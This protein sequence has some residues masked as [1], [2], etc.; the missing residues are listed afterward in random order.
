MKI[1]F[2][3]NAGVSN[4]PGGGRKGGGGLLKKVVK[5]VRGLT[6]ILA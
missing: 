2:F 5:K 3:V 6:T 1:L 4:M